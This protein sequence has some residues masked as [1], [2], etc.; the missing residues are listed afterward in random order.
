MKCNEFKEKVADLFDKTIDM[1]TQA[2]LDEHM[3]SCPECKAYYEELRETFNMLQPR[4]GVKSEE[5]KAKNNSDF[6]APRSSLWKTAAIFIA[7]AFLCGLSFAA[8]HAIS[9]KQNTDTVT[10]QEPRML[11]A[12]FVPKDCKNP[13]VRERGDAITAKWTKGTW[14]QHDH[15][16]FVEEHKDGGGYMFHLNFYG[17]HRSIVRLD[18]KE[19]DI[20][21]LPDLPASALKKVEIHRDDNNMVV[22]L[23]TT[24]VRVPADVK[25]NVNPELTIL[26]TGTV[27]KGAY[28]PVTI[29]KSKGIKESYDW[30]D[31]IYTSWTGQWENVRIHL[32]EAVNRKD[33]HV[34]INVCKGTPQKHIDRIKSIMQ[35]C[36]VTNYE[37][38]K[39]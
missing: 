21:N 6:I 18:G 2:E 35:E 36:G 33:H 4:G 32:K 38:V 16:S 30:H 14:V 12:F 34:R 23:I 27:P 31:Y 11:G 20:H 29:W 15:N 19:L 28:Q 26:L 3:K 17:K 24:P 22:N 39:Q 8:Y 25:G 5:T 37:I 1:Q 9:L 13:V 7:A 10:E